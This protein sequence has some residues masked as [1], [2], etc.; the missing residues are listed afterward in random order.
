[1]TVRHSRREFIGMTAA[2]GVLG[3]AGAAGAAGEEQAPSARQDVPPGD[4]IQ[5]ATI[6]V[7]IQGINDTRTALRLPGVELVA[8]ADVYEGRLTLARETWG[9]HLFTSRDYREVLARPDVDAVIIATPDHWHARMAIDA[10]KAGKDVYVEKP[11][12]QDIEEGPEVIAVEKQTR[13]ILQVGS[14]RASSMVYAKARDLFKAGAIGE[15]NLV[16]AWMN[17]N[18]SNGAWQYSIPPDASPATIDWDRFIG[19]APKRPFEPIRL[20]RWRNY[21]DYGTGI[22]GDLFVHLFTGI[23]FVLDSLGPT[24]VMATGGLRYWHDG[25]DVPDV[26]LALY[27]YPKTAAHP[28]FTLA[29]K[30]NFANGGGN[31][32]AFRFIGPEGMMTLTGG[33]VTLSRRPRPKDPGTTADTFA[34]AMQDAYLKE[35]RA[36]YPEQAELLPTSEEV[37][38]APSGYNESLEHFR[39]FF[40]AV[41]A[42]RAVIED[43]SF[44]YRAAAPALLTNDSYFEA[45]PVGWDPDRMRRGAV[46]T[47]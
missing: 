15:L 12:V 8:A 42:R 18:S 9:E 22:P 46:K 45:K 26:M 27:D 7:G 11:I 21:R 31:D 25:R 41:R 29:L 35:H 24:R 39:T 4:R 20:F 2:A 3:A 10:M 38:A 47:N 6:G 19:N 23:H 32:Q 16:E 14:Q 33:A 17:R 13:R 36:K 34:K 44:G 5:I 30:V 40:D 1:M 37:Y 43:A 28:A